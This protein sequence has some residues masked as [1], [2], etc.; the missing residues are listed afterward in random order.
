MGGGKSVCAPYQAARSGKAAAHTISV[1]LHLF[2]TNGYRAGYAVLPAVRG[3][4][5]SWTVSE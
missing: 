3:I 2:N 5:D 1:A 4:G